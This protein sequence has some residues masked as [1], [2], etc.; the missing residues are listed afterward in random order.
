MADLCGHLNVLHAQL[1]DAIV[2]SLDGGLWEQWGIRSP[3]HWLAWQ[4][5]MTPARARQLVDTARR[6]SELPVTFAAFA[7]GELSVDQVVTVAKYTPA[8]NDTE[9]CEL[10]K[11]ATVSQLRNALSKYVHV[12]PN[13]APASPVEAELAGGDARN[14]LVRGFDENNRY[15]LALNAPTDQGEIINQAIREARDAMF[16]AGHKTVTWLEAFV[17]VCNRSLGTVTSP[18]RRDRFRA[19]IHLNT[20]DDG[21]PAH[22]WFNGGPSLADAIRDVLLCDGIVQPLWHTGGLPINVGRARYIV[23]PHTRRQ[24]LDR[25]RT[26]LKPGCQASTHLEVHHIWDWLKGGPTQ[27]NNLG[28]LCDHHHDALHRGEFIMIGNPDIPGDLN[29][30]DRNG[31]PIPNSGTPNRPTGPPPAPPPG[32]KYGHPTG[33]RFDTRWFQLIEPPPPLL[34]AVS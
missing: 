18:S 20:D 32:K 16:L 34:V 11:S 9:V 10:A 31:R 12:E 13:T 19:Y 7:D 24:V 22:A 6:K 2:E 27:T 15:T 14:S 4:T 25:D 3:E 30:Y 26:C 5:G 21:G 33:E 1:V 17:E 8:H 28:A 29:F 23:P